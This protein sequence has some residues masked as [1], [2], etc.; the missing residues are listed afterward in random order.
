MSQL[1]P[2]SA[3]RRADAQRREAQAAAARAARIADRDGVIRPV[4]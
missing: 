1:S 3:Q 2:R 4:Q